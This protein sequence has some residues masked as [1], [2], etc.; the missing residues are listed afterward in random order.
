MVQGNSDAMRLLHA[1]ARMRARARNETISESEGL[2]LL[3][4]TILARVIKD[5]PHTAADFAQAEHVSQQAIAQCVDVLKARQLV[6]TRPD[7][8]D[9]RKRLIEATAAGRRVR[10]TVAEARAAWLARAIAQMVTREE[11]RTLAAAIELL[12]RIADAEVK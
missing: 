10:D 12:E 9:R 2:S 5:G 8:N 3:Q 11:R 6:R 1:V 4:V 7:P